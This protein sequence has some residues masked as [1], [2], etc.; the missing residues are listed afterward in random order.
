MCKGNHIPK[1]NSLITC[2][3]VPEPFG[4]KAKHNQSGMIHT[5]KV[6][7]YKNV[8]WILP[9]TSFYQNRK[10][11]KKHKIKCSSLIRSL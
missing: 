5:Q 8:S 2:I 7:F 3:F 9:F 4:D 11:K 1:T 10:L 6:V